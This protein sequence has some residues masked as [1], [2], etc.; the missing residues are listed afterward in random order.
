MSKRGRKNSRVDQRSNL[1]TAR[2]GWKRLLIYPLLL[3]NLF[4]FSRVAQ[5]GYVE[6]AESGRYFV[7]DGKPFLIVGLNDALTWPGLSPLLNR[8]APGAVEDYL[9]DLVAHGVNTVRV[10]IE[11]AQTPQG[12]L[13][14]PLG[15]YNP[16]VVQFWDDF[17]ALAERY[18]L[19]LIVTPWDPF[20]MEKN[21]STNPYNTA[22]GG[23]VPTMHGFLTDEKA[24]AEQKR[25]F[26]FIIERWGA[27]EQI[28]AWELMNEIELWWGAG[29][30]ELYD[31][32]SMMAAFVRQTEL[33]LYG[34]THLLTVSSANPMP[35]G[36]LARAIYNHPDLDFA[37]THLYT[38][39][40]M[41][42]PV[43]T[44]AVVE[45]VGLA[46]N[47]ALWMIEDRRPYTDTESGPIEMWLGNTRM[48]AE[49]LHNV[50]FA[51]LFSGGAGTGMRWPYRVPH[52][53]S[54]E[55]LDALARVANFIAA[56]D[57]DGFS[58]ENITGDLLT[59]DDLIPCAIG[60][61][62][63]SMIWLVRKEEAVSGKQEE[64][65]IEGLVPGDYEVKFWDPWR[66]CWLQQKVIAWT[67]GTKIIT[68]AFTKDLIFVLRL[69][70]TP[71]TLISG[72]E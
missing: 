65:V 53:L 33:E 50:S 39:P 32:I 48:D 6:V 55:M 25:R 47:Y 23:V 5:S 10:M 22:N 8:M 63:T 60:D 14:N 52:I 57:W 54:A 59:T 29:G 64:V 67:E 26:R 34:K 28:L 66:S 15:T 19:H 58:P 62:E 3:I 24:I 31:W 51:H 43:N 37:T 13:E 11:Y 38:G 44:T 12:L 71:D 18:D 7:K 56:V 4:C 27:S 46:V 41:N 2:Q 17:F 30:P 70:T 61:D 20:W 21:W 42:S 49:F 36:T 1:R 35:S 68:P 9:H 40:G 72:S 45:E 16:M 69:K